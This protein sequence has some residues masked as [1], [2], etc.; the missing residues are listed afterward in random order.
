M[1]LASADAISLGVSIHDMASGELAFRKGTAAKP[2]RQYD[3]KA[4]SLRA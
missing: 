1:L 4:E 3:R 2:L